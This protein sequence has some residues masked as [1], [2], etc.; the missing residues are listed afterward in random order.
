MLWPVPGWLSAVQVQSGLEQFQ[1]FSDEPGQG[2]VRTKPAE[3][4]TMLPS[5][6]NVAAGQFPSGEGNTVRQL[7]GQGHTVRGIRVT[8]CTGRE[9]AVQAYM[10]ESQCRVCWTV[11]RET[12]VR[13]P[14]T[15]TECICRW[16]TPLR[17]SVLPPA[18]STPADNDTS[19]RDH[20]V[21]NYIL[22][23]YH[24]LLIPLKCTSILQYITSPVQLS[25]AAMLDS[26]QLYACVHYVI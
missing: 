16:R 5:A 18:T 25:L 3:G 8:W 10:L 4:T 1:Q 7:S 9:S 14:T 12:C 21:S 24:Y 15:A 11:G 13:D 17:R 19:H 22:C 6:R 2:H 26:R 23:Y 20:L